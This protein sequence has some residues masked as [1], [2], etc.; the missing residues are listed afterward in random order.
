MYEHRSNAEIDMA[1]E[2]FELMAEVLVDQHYVS[3]PAEMKKAV[4]DALAA[5]AAGESRPSGTP[6]QRLKKEVDEAIKASERGSE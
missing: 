4:A 5:A 3:G 1:D 6:R 2:K